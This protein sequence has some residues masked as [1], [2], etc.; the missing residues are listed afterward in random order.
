MNLNINVLI[1]NTIIFK[2]QNKSLDKRRDIVQVIRFSAT[3]KNGINI[4]VKR[5]TKFLCEI[6]KGFTTRV[7]S[8]TTVRFP[9][10]S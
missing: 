2:P 1:K 5:N 6:C 10:R 3:V 7:H 4:V 8:A 9:S